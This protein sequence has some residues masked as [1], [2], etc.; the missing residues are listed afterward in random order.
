MSIKIE[1]DPTTIYETNLGISEREA[2]HEFL[3]SKHIDDMW[4]K[5][6][7]YQYTTVQGID[8][9]FCFTQSLLR[10]KRSKGKEGERFEIFDLSSEPLGQGGYATVYPI[11]GTI[12]F[13]TNNLIVKTNKNIVG[14]TPAMRA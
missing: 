6:Q 14:I 11:L 8:Y 1:L 10:R 12:K 3:K 4:I 2:L 5:N 9:V 7:E 13:E